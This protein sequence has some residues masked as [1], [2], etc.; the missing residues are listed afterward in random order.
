MV[1]L[2]REKARNMG[3]DANIL[4]ADARSFRLPKPF[5]VV[6]CLFGTLGYLHEDD[7]VE[8]FFRNTFNNLR[9]GGLFIFDFP[10][11]EFFKTHGVKPSVL[12]GEK[13]DLKSIRV[14]LPKFN[15]ETRFLTLLFK[16]IIYKDRELIDLFEETHELRTFDSLEIQSFLEESSFHVVE[17]LEAGESVYVTVVARKLEASPD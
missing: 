12:E 10:S 11:F 2:A 7:E 17:F 9:D 1:E 4:L 14:S 16:C 6:T 5:D 13:D 8:S 3:V 15:L